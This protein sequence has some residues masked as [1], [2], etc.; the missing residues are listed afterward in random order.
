MLQRPL[1]LGAHLSVHSTTKYLGGHEDV[2]GGA[3]IAGAGLDGDNDHELFRRIRLLQN[4]YGAVPAPFDCWLVMRGIR[5]LHLRMPA[6]CANA[7]KVARFLQDHPGI[8][9]V[10]Y[11]GLPGHPGHSIAAG[12]MA[13][14]G[15]MLSCQVKGGKA[16]ALA[17][18]GRVKVFVRATSLGG[19]QSLIEHRASIEGPDTATPDDLLR[20]S[21]GLEN[22]DDLI[23]DLAQAWDK[24]T[25][26]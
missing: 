3:V 22:A 6:H 10:H 25:A 5:T 13:G 16:A 2:T 1:A 12:Q 18:A 26:Q 11:P 24:Q 19:T 20:L 9:A 23:G 17:V 7:G 15:G 4:L 8:A 14:F 21:I